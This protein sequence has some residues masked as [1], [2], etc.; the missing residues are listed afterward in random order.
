M[1]SWM[2]G[3]TDVNIRLLDLKHEETFQSAQGGS[4]EAGSSISKS[5]FPQ[6]LGPIGPIGVLTISYA[7]GQ[8]TRISKLVARWS[9]G[10]VVQFLMI[11]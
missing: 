11:I 7:I 10:L 6:K 8:V 5:I 2:D 9:G 3:R 4:V 1:P